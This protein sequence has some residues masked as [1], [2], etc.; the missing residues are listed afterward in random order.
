MYKRQ[1]L[2]CRSSDNSHDTDILE[3]FFSLSN[4]D[5]LIYPQSNFSMIPALIHDFATSC[6]V[7]SGLKMNE[8][9]SHIRIDEEQT[10]IVIERVRNAC[11]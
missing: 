1:T 9:K 3:D 7:I 8:M 10:Q 5:S 2:D 6:T 4:F 11:K